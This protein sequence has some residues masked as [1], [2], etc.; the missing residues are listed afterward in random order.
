LSA[1][2]GF[3]YEQATWG[4]EDVRPGDHTVAGHALLEAGFALP[5]SGTV[6]EL[7]CGAGR[8]LGG[9]QRLRPDLSWAGID[10]SRA[11]LSVAE[12]RFPSM[13]FRL[14]PDP[15]DPL[16]ARDGEFD[17]VLV[18]DV[19]E[20]VDDP[21]AAL[22]ELRRVLAPGGRIHLHVPCEG[23]ALSLWRWLPGPLGRLKR[24]YA[25][26]VQRF[27]R[28][29]IAMLLESAGFRVVRTRYSLH[30]LGNLADVAV[31]SGI[32]LLQRWRRGEA[33]LTTGDVLSGARSGDARP[34]ARVGG[35]GV[36]LVDAALWLEARWL[37]RCPSWCLHVTA[38]RR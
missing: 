30:I 16:P 9:L 28:A 29:E 17:A 26:H 32:A 3:D 10:V 27:R 24:R 13:D 20:H 38:V 31:F 22:A 1:G 33:P 21:A 11:A 2:T 4:R 35:W 12:D 36:K 18:L 25:G 8:M 19:L 15:T 37:G 5:A 34:W 7:G 23:D 14:L 6:L